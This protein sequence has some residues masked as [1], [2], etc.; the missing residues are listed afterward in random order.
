MSDRS[1][2]EIAGLLVDYA[3]GQLSPEDSG[4]VAEHLAGCAACRAIVKG[5]HKSLELS[6]IIWQDNL[7][8]AQNLPIPI[9]Q[10]AAKRHWAGYAA[11]AAAILVFVTASV[12]RYLVRGPGEH[13]PS[14]AE[15][16][17]RVI[18]EGTA[19]KLLAAAELLAGKSYANGLVK[20]QYRYIVDNY[21]HTQ[22]AAKVKT[23]IQGDT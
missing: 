22:A 14:L 9:A 6:N 18:D 15:I 16:E 19:A 20:S 10:T 12:V 21:P 7:E 3:D 1:C 17:R 5:L 13:G 8:Q 2:E 23:L 4:K 11:V